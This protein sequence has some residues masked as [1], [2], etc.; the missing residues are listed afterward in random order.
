MPDGTQTRT[1]ARCN[2]FTPDRSKISRIRRWVISKSVMAPPRRGRTATMWPGV[3]PIMCHAWLPM[4]STSWVRLFRAMT[5]GSKRMIPRPR[6]YTRVFAVPRSMA[7][8]SGTVGS[9][10]GSGGPELADGAHVVRGLGPCGPAVPVL[11]LP[12]RH[13]LLQGVDG[14]PCGFERLRSVGRRCNHEHRRFRQFEVAES[15]QQR[16]SFDLRPLPTRLRGDLTEARERGIFVRL[17]RERGDAVATVGMVAYHTEEADDRT[18]GRGGGPR[19]GCVGGQHLVR[20]CDPV[21]R[22]RR[23]VRRRRNDRHGCSLYRRSATPIPA[24]RG[25]AADG[26]T[27]VSTLR[28]MP[29]DD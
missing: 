6:A 23:I 11:L 3:R 24:D 4:A 17:V 29:A 2:R 1:R 14:E 26:R 21:G 7:R 27:G 12:D 10:S 20:E 13:G 15:V 9:R 5:V 22:S 25:G 28:S 18:R 16:E 19:G 8:S